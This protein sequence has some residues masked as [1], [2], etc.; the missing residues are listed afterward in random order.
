L[1]QLP[2]FL[3][4][5]DALLADF[6]AVTSPE[7]VHVVEFRHPTWYAAPVFALLEAAGAAAC[8]VSSPASNT[9][10]LQVGPI[11]YLRFHGAQVFAASRYS[12]PELADWAA[13][14]R[15]AAAAR[16]GPRAV[17]AYFDNDVARLRGAQRSRA[18][19]PARRRPRG[20]GG[21]RA[22][23]RARPVIS[24]RQPPQPSVTCRPDGRPHAKE[25]R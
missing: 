18:A 20:G 7:F 5:S 15:S 11:V 4:R 16:S 17:Y 25:G 19:C 10:V 3:Q 14:I 12:V 8:S 24:V 6:L 23:S 2:P 13:A 9:G 21:P 22:G 1:F